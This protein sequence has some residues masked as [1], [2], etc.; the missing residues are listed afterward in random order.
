MDPVRSSLPILLAALLLAACGREPPQE[1]P[2]AFLQGRWIPADAASS[3]HSYCFLRDDLIVGAA[4]NRG[5]SVRCRHVV[6]RI[7]TIKDRGDGRLAIY[8]RDPSYAVG[9]DGGPVGEFTTMRSPERGH[10]L[11]RR[12]DDR[13]IEVEMVAGQDVLTP[14]RK[15]AT[16]P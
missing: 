16:P 13:H 6:R 9:W 3:G 4:G 14:F 5:G 15:V 11:V 12:I 7:R 10:L 1:D 2:G 8:F